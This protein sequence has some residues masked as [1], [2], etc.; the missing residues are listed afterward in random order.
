MGLPAC[1]HLADTVFPAVRAEAARRLTEQGWTQSR[2]AERL[3]V[4]Q[5]M[6]SKYLRAEVSQDP[7]VLRLA[8]DLV[9]ESDES[10][11]AVLAET[12]GGRDAALAD[13]LEAERRLLAASPLDIMPQ[14]GLNLA[15]ALP[16]AT[17][18]AQV[19][20]YPARIVADGHRFLRPAPPRA[21]AS[22]H[23]AACLLAW[24]EHRPEVHAIANIRGGPNMRG[25]AS[26]AIEIDG[27][28]DRAALIRTHQPSRILHDMGAV[29]IEPCLYIAGATATEVVD[30]ILQ[31]AQENP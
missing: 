3:Q 9:H 27:D 7:L 30:R 20:A 31:I 4:S 16:D 24:Q 8:D 18:P 12:D 28:G 14:V 26:E 10:W 2:I 11:C 22:T 15:R 13:L 6:V 29:G 17:G 5:A 25:R 19:L 21:G 1:F 23:L